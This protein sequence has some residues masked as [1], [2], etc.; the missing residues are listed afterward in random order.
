MILKQVVEKLDLNY[1]FQKKHTWKSNE[2]LTKESLPFEIVF[3]DETSQ[4][5]CIIKYQKENVIIE[6][7]D[8][9]F[10]FSK[11]E[12]IIE[13]SIFKYKTKILNNII[14]GTYIIDQFTINETVNELKTRYGL[15]NRKNQM[16]MEYLILVLTRK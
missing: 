1:R 13:N 15:I 5:H 6:I 8:N 9:T 4:K 12:S 7:N 10:S 3:K 2:V 14:Q 16:F 11:K